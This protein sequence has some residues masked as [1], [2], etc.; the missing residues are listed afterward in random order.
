MMI[1]IMSMGKNAS[2]VVQNS[3]PEL[4]SRFQVVHDCSELSHHGAV[5]ATIQF[6]NKCK[7]DPR[8]Y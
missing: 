1:L 2:F 4:V 6:L 7:E 3:R 5:R 8:S